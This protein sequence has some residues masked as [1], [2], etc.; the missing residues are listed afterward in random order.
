MS[1]RF[2]ALL[3]GA[4]LLSFASL[5]AEAATKNWIGCPVK[6]FYDVD[7]GPK[8]S[9]SWS[10]TGAAPVI[11]FQATRIVFGGGKGLMTPAQLAQ[12]TPYLD[13]LREASS[14]KLKVQ[15]FYDDVT[16]SILAIDT[17]YNT[18]C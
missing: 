9:V 1:M 5:S 12:W 15:V 14:R 2:S 16:K 18:P 8:L 4:A 17:L 6:S 13:E 11:S 10:V 7:T 3:I